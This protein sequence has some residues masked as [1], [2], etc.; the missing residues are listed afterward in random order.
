MVIELILPLF[1]VF[2]ATSRRLRNPLAFCLMMVPVVV[3][4]NGL[5]I[6]PIIV[7]LYSRLAFLP[8]F[9]ASVPDILGTVTIIV[10]LGVALEQ[11]WTRDPYG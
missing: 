7:Q 8:V 10:L 11:A 1:T 9:T 3:G 5:D 2:A 6:N 4:M